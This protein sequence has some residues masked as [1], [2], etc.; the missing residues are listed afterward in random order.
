M[1]NTICNIGP[2]QVKY[3]H[4]IAYTGEQHGTNPVLFVTQVQTLPHKH[5]AVAPYFFI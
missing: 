3:N 4:I 5:T 1:E 2:K